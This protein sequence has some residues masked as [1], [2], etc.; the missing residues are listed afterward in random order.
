[1]ENY[2]SAMP[3]WVSMLF[4]VSFLLSLTMI[5]RPARQ[6]ALNAGLTV[7]RSKIIQLGIILFYLLWLGYASALALSGVLYRNSLPPRVMMFIT[8]PLFVILFAFVGNTRLY[9]QL[10]RSAALESLI[11]MHVFRFVGVFFFLLYF[12]NVVDP[13]FAVS[14]GL[15]DIITAIFAIPVARA[16]AQKRSWAI[17][18]VV[19]W[20]IVGI[21][22][23]LTLLTIATLGAI[24]SVGAG[25]QGGG[26]MTMF[27]FVWF[28]A[29]APATILFLHAGVFRK[30]RQTVAAVLK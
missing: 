11:F 26:E 5:I 3:L 25:V 2:F 6:A 23:I 7:E 22:D 24:R 29:F 15:G 13:D 28:P 16:V 4:I 8:L 20:N 21:L 14:A 12:Y 10:L 1:M 30:L 17:K 9:K 18:A 19:V 27:P